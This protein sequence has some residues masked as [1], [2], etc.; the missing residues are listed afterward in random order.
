[1]RTVAKLALAFTLFAGASNAFETRFETEA[2]DSLTKALKASSAVLQA[3]QEGVETSEEIIAAVQ[4]DYGT[5]LSLLY[6]EGYYGPVISIKVDGREGAD[7]SLISLPP[8]IDRVTISVTPGPRFVFGD[9][10]VGPLTPGTELPADFTTGE[11]ARAGLVG[12]AS[13]AAVDAWRQASHAKAEPT[14]QRVVAD[15]R[16]KTLD[17][18][19]EI[20]PGPPVTFGTLSFA[21][22]SQVKEQR[23]ERIAN[24]PSGAAYDPDTLTL[25][26]SRLQKTG[27]F[28]SITLREAET[29]NPD[30]SLD[31]T[32]TLI[33]ERRRRFGFGAEVSSL[34]G[35]T[36]SAYWMHRNI[37]NHADR[38]RFD[39][40]I[41]GLGGSTGVDYSLSASYRR[42]ATPSKKTTLVVGTSIEHLD[43]PDFRSDTGEFTFGVDVESSLISTFSTS[44]GYRYSDVDDD[45]G[46]RIFHHLIF[47][48][49]GTRDRRDNT[50]NPKDGSYFAA[51][52][53]P[54]LG[55]YGSESGARL[56]VDGRGYESFGEDDRF[57][58]AARLQLGSIIGADYTEVPPDMLFHSGGGGTVRGQPY[59]SLGVDVGPLS[60]GGSSFVGL[61]TE[62]RSVV[63]GPISLVGFL[64]VGGVGTDALPGADAEWHSGAGLGLRY[65]TGVGPIRFDVAAPV[66]GSTSDGVQ[67]YIGIGQAF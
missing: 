9:A 34:E 2:D 41:A 62:L 37:T 10:N 55:L 12:D 32:A 57:T 54:F 35:G 17:V 61:S 14:S 67:F 6:R 38:L 29:L 39:G 53:M 52:I 56:F 63:R 46:H 42:P 60:S 48:V 40:E 58:F 64:D 25:V 4:A 43:E 65:D 36:L 33:D 7:M 20:D 51:E 21:G 44:I 15:H 1:M 31:I 49:E 3:R 5:L 59:Q 45:F 47:P 19:I 16:D 11:I 18:D 30:G 50:L 26:S 8:Q 24:F 23:L 22:R 66:S 27:T 13:D 28:R